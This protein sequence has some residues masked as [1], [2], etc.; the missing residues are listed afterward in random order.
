MKNFNLAQKS[1]DILV[2]LYSET[3]FYLVAAIVAYH[4]MACIHGKHIILSM[5]LI[6]VGVAA[7][8]LESRGL[9]LTF[10]LATICIFI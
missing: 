2:S 5:L 9:L 10:V 3:K 4:M 8:T 6:P 1:L 7:L